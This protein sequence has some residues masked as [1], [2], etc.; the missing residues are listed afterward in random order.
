MSQ[1]QSQLIIRI[2]QEF[3]EQAQEFSKNLGLSLSGLVKV[4]LKNVVKTKEVILKEGNF[5]NL[6]LEICKDK[7]ISS[8]LE[9]LADKVTKKYPCSL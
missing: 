1:Q 3:K 7:E 6:L 2:D 9:T 5:D 4:L 8:K